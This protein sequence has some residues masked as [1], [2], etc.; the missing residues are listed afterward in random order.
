MVVAKEFDETVL[1]RLETIGGLPLV[2]RM[3]D[4]FL[5]HAPQR[6]ESAR[7][8][9]QTGDMDAVSRAAHS[10]KSSAG[11]LCLVVL[12]ELAEDMERLATAAQHEGLV[13]KLRDLE[14]AFARVTPVL[15]QHRSALGG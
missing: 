11:H 8:G 10:L 4:L 6:L 3:L 2:R 5:E 7:L 12:Q 9:C 1:T 15:T 13:G 14:E